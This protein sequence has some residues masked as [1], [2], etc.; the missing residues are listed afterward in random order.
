[1]M[2][3]GSFLTAFWLAFATISFLVGMSYGASRK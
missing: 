2:P 1:M 3:D